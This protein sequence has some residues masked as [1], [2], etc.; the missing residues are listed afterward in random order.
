MDWIARLTE[1]TDDFAAELAEGDLGAAVPSC[2]GWT[3]AD[4][5]EHLRKVHLWAA[6]AVSDGKP[7]GMP[8][9][10]TA[11]RPA[12]TA[13][14]LVEGYPAAAAHLVE[15][16]S[17]AAP[18][19]AAWTFGPEQKAGFWRRRQVHEAL[20][21]LYDAMLANGTAALWDPEPELAWDGVDEVATLFYPR[22][23]RLDRTS[24][25]VRPLRLTATDVDRSLTLGEGDDPIELALPAADLLLALWKREPVADADAA[26]L[27]TAAAVTP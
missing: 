14:E 17:A 11:A 3:L 8:D 22:Q 27:L 21:H 20:V 23:V 6:H 1:L 4:L 2:P 24:A 26:A 7:D 12:M 15:V 5:G 19:D 18:E 16:L 13:E 9:A 10:T 25:L